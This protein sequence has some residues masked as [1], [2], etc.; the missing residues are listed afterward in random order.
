RG[1]ASPLSFDSGV[2]ERA[3]DRGH[4]QEI[5]GFGTHARVV[6]GLTE[7]GRDCFGGIASI[8]QVVGPGFALLREA[9]AEERDEL[10]GGDAELREAGLRAEAE[11]AGVDIGRRR[12]GAGW[13]GKE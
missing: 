5:D 8:A 6:A 7:G 10:S 2:A 9:S 13:K 1:D 4:A 11:D 12:E 3:K